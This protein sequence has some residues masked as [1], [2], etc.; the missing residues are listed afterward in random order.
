M[1]RKFAESALAAAD[2]LPLLEGFDVRVREQQRLVRDVG[3]ARLIR[4]SLSSERYTRERRRCQASRIHA[5]IG[6]RSGCWGRQVGFG[7]DCLQPCVG[8]WF[9]MM[10]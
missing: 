2:G 3:L 7:A 10:R 6:G 9:G 5:S 8:G 1:G 4:C